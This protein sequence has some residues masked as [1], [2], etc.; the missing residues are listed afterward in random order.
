[1]DRKFIDFSQRLESWYASR[2]GKYLAG[3]ER[4]EVSRSLAK[5]YRERM[6]CLSPAPV[7]ELCAGQTTAQQY[8]LAEQGQSGEADLYAAYSELPLASGSIDVVVL[9]HALEACSNPHQLLREVQRVIAPRG[10][11]IIV[12]FNPWSLHGLWSFLTRKFPSSVW[13]QS[14]IGRRRI[15]DWLSL[16]GFGVEA[17]SHAYTLP[18]PDVERLWHRFC[19]ANRFLSRHRLPFGGVQIYH[20]ISQEHGMTALRPDWRPAAPR[21]VGLSVPRPAVSA[22]RER[23]PST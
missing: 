19:R 3:L 23:S 4:E 15:T 21:L 20:A 10:H 6:L 18:P 12:C 7:A 17:V 9:H 8:V 1:M 2:R 16:L 13:Q 5:V 11:L 14:A 22:A